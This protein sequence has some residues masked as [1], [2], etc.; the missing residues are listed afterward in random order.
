MWTALTCVLLLGLILPARAESLTVFAAASTADAI[1][2]IARL[3]ESRTGIPVRTSVASSST[4]ARQIE[5]GAPAD[6]YLSASRAWMDH[7]AQR[8]L[9]EA[10][11]RSSLLGN[12]LVL[13]APRDSS[14][15]LTIASDFAL[16]EALGSGPLAM[17][18]PDHVP[19]GIYGKEALRSLGV[20]S[21]VEGRVARTAD[22]RA[23][24]AL[25]ARGEAAAGITYATEA[26]ITPAVR[27]VAVFP[28]ESHSP[29][30]YEVALIAGRGDPSARRFL[31]FLR[32][33][34]ALA[35]FERRGFAVRRGG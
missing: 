34:A 18:D 9:I 6:V 8:G 17:G 23:A 14:L 31:D 1:T 2:E 10:G 20:W 11:S 15:A 35:I 28:P 12:R 19:A 30:A 33:A 24:L 25:V 16:A 27:V 4:L 5:H 29:V 3:F 7:L 26:A 13:I 32:S 21:K 22:V